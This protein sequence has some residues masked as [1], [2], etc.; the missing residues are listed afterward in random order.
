MRIGLSPARKQL[1]DYRPARVTVCVLVYIP[2]WIGYYAYRFDV[3]K[4]CLQSIIKHTDITYDLLVFDNGSCSE[5]VDY[6]RSL[7]DQKIIQYLILSARNIGKIGAL[8]IMFQA[9]P[10]EVVAY[11]DD[12]VLFHPD[13]LQAQ[14]EILDTFPR[15]GMVSGVPVRQQFRYGNEY[16]TGYL[17]SFPDISVDYGHFIPDEWEREF[18]LSTSQEADKRVSAAKDA[19]KDILLEYNGIKA[20][21]TANHFQFLSPK[22]VI[23][24]GL[25]TK[26]SGRLMGEL[27]PGI[28]DG[29][30]SGLDERIDR[31]G[32]ARLSTFGRFVQHIGNII[33]HDFENAISNLGLTGEVRC[34]VPPKPLLIRLARQKVIRHILVKLANGLYFLLAY[35]QLK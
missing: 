24:Q 31:L 1:S 2:E 28:E 29:S 15:V 16:L 20:Y 7:Q 9:A 13:W 10:G 8:K 17:S 14:L 23:L 32:Y 27:G 34:W 25:N 19:Y 33:T 5:V 4:L 35:R 12:D 26:W 30:E 11:S 22:G 21:S 3:L 18:Y 6:L